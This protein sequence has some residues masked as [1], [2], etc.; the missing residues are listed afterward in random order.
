[1]PLEHA[2]RPS[3]PAIYFIFYFCVAAW[4]HRNL[5]PRI[6]VGEADYQVS[7]II[8]GLLVTRSEPP[9]F[10]ARRD[11]ILK[12]LQSSKLGLHSLLFSR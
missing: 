6:S 7:W 8:S 11:I 10:G 5:L 3:V 1:M 2:G 4:G 12:R 9:Q